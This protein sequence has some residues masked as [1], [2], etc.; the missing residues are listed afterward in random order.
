MTA[1]QLA[2]DG[3]DKLMHPAVVMT[4]HQ[5]RNDAMIA[6]VARLYIPDGAVVIDA[7]WGRGAFW[8]RTDTSRFRLTG[9]DIAAPGSPVRGDFRELPFASGC[10]D[11]LVLDPPYVHSTTRPRA[12]HGTYRNLETTRGLTYRQIMD[13]YRDAISAGWR[14]LKP[15]GLCWVKCQ[16]TVAD[17]KQHWSVVNVHEIA[18]TLGYEAQ[19]LFVLVNPSPPGS[20]YAERQY[21]ARR[22]HSY[23]WIFRKPIRPP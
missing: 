14:V 15:G 17:H 6:A 9:C 18:A 2:L 7:T 8:S 1:A 22:N 23:L 4:A 16:D 5:G 10:A 21:H 20:R 19:D 11:V 3:M 12:I 13:L